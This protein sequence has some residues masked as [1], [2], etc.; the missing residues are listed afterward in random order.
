MTKEE[1]LLEIQK[2]LNTRLGLIL[3][4]YGIKRLKL[5]SVGN[6]IATGFSMARL[7]KPLLLRNESIA[8]IMDL[9]G[10]EYEP[11]K[12]SRAQN[13]GDEHIYEWLVT[14]KKESEINESNIRD[15]KQGSK[16]K[17]PT[18]DIDDKLEEYF[19]TKE[20]DKGMQEE[21]L[22]SND[23]LA[24]I[25]IY[26]GATGSVL[27]NFT[28]GG[29]PFKGIKRDITALEATLKYIQ[30]MNRE[31]GTN[32]QIFLC[33]APNYLGLG[34]TNIIN[35]KLK[36]L[37]MEYANVTYVPPIKSKFIYKKMGMNE[38]TNPEEV[39]TFLQKLQSYSVDIHYDELEYLKFNNNIMESIINNYAIKRALINIDRKLYKLSTEIELENQTNERIEKIITQLIQEEYSQ[40]RT[41][42]EK[43][44]FLHLARKYLINRFPYDFYYTGKDNI[45]NSIASI[46]K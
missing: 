26:N 2:R 3:K 21:L 33:G 34:I 37:A 22:E 46:K 13:N 11:H 14:N 9:L 25:V 1:E 28:R 4:K 40:L 31:K 10:I 42:E 35:H 16:I 17:M 43:N 30:S 41:K 29:I 39:Q 6:S 24:N 44:T 20:S 36:K 18:A 8:T 38:P 19:P 27:D 32:T 45:K 12:F 23:D 15:Y 7:T 5:S